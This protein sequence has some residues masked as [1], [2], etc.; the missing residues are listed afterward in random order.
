MP[1]PS[2]AAMVNAYA[3]LLRR[4]RECE[5]IRG[6]LPN[7]AGR[8]LLPARR[9]VKVVDTLNGIDRPGE[10]KGVTGAVS[11]DAVDVHVDPL[12]EE[13]DHPGDRQ[14]LSNREVV[15]P[16]QVGMENL[17]VPGRTS[18]RWSGPC[19]GTP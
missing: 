7:L 13:G 16:G 11:Q 8:E 12:V 10:E 17:W 14:Q 4:A 5:R 1:L 2:D 6:H 19:T 15:G 18:S 9:P 3:P